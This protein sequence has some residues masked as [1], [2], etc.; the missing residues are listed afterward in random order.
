MAT[1]SLAVKSAGLDNDRYIRFQTGHSME[2]IAK[3]DGVSFSE[4]QLSIE[5]AAREDHVRRQRALIDLRM[6]AQIENEKIRK[7]TR[8]K[9]AS[10]AETALGKLLIGER[11]VVQKNKETGELSLFSYTDVDTIALGLEHFR[12]SISLEEKPAPAPGMVV[13]VQSNTTQNNI[14][15]GPMNGGKPMSFEERIQMI[16]QK[17]RES[18][19]GMPPAEEL[20]DSSE[21]EILQGEVETVIERPGT[22]DDPW[23]I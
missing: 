21:P 7:R 4:V 13:N 20:N 5:S 10:E 1:E 9:F 6:E 23:A 22:G 19:T 8:I 17:Q 16:R 18:L 12:K 15:G 2:E 11:T 14:L 3:D